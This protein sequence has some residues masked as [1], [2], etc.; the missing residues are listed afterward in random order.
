MEVS[1]QLHTPVNFTLRKE[2]PVATVERLIKH[3]R[4]VS[5]RAE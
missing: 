3:E 2:T 5:I 1:G 4:S